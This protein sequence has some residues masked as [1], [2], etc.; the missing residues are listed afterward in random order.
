MQMQN[1]IIKADDED[2][3]LAARSSAIPEGAI[4]SGVG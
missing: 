3:R 4:G 2:A 1:S